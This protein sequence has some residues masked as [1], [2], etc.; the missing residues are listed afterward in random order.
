LFTR[1]HPHTYPQ[2]LW[3]TFINFWRGISIFYWRISPAVRAGAILTLSR[4]KLFASTVQPKVVNPV[5]IYVIAT[6]AA[7][8]TKI[9]L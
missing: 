1:F 5:R 2:H 4:T 9:I 3:K 7:G 6:G 8:D